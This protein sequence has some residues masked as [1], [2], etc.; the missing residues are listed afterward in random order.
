MYGRVVPNLNK[1]I[2]EFSK[3]KIDFDNL[4]RGSQMWYP[5]DYIELPEDSSCAIVDEADEARKIINEY[6]TINNY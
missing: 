1:K 5:T 4:F 3:G 6:D 2:Y